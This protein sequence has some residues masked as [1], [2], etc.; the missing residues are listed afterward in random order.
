MIMAIEAVKPGEKSDSPY[1]DGRYDRTDVVETLLAQ[2]GDLTLSTSTLEL[3]VRNLNEATAEKLLQLNTYKVSKTLT[4]AMNDM[5]W[6]PG[7]IYHI[8]CRWG[9]GLEYLDDQE[10]IDHFLQ[11]EHG[12]S[13]L[14]SAKAS[15]NNIRTLVERKII[16]AAPKKS[17]PQNWAILDHLHRATEIHLDDEAL[18]HL[19]RESTKTIYSNKQVL[20]HMLESGATGRIGAK[21]FD[22]F[23]NTCMDRDRD[24]DQERRLL[25][26]VIGQLPPLPVDITE[27]LIS[28]AKHGF[29]GRTALDYVLGPDHDITIHQSALQ[30]CARLG[31]E[32]WLYRLLNRMSAKE[33]TAVDRKTLL[34]AAR[35]GGKSSIIE[36]CRSLVGKAPLM[37]SRQ[38]SVRSFLKRAYY[39]MRQRLKKGR[40]RFV[41]P[42]RRGFLRFLLFSR[43][44]IVGDGKSSHRDGHPTI[45]LGLTPTMASTAIASP[46][47]A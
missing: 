31:E 3:A 36:F 38:K 17:S 11:T 6:E 27:E 41:S 39:T 13:L 8:L 23:W 2:A 28:A 10:V 14:L 12:R 43:R 22:E 34:E 1:F 9:E 15:D 35:E 42:L 30:K 20:L 29:D 47:S 16:E 7:R 4:L 37:V 21:I 40:P 45:W 46:G 5:K 24:R 32:L 25:P 18:A 19:W 26:R 44:R 33:I